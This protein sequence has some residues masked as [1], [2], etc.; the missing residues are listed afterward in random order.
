MRRAVGAALGQL[1]RD[2]QRMRLGA[3]P[4]ASRDDAFRVLGLLGTVS[5]TIPGLA[6]S[7]LRQPSVYVHLRLAADGAHDPVERLR[8]GLT[9]LALELAAGGALSEPLELAA[10]ARRV[11][12]RSR[13]TVLT[14]ATGPVT[15]T[16]DGLAVQEGRR[17][18]ERRAFVPIRGPLALALEDDSPLAAVEAHPDKHGSRLDLGGA[19]PEAWRASLADA[20]RRLEAHL[21]AMADELPVVLSQVVPVGVDPERHLSA[22]YREG[23]GTIYLSLHPDPLTMTEAVLHEV[24]H[25]KLHAVL[26]VQ[27]LLD[28]DPLER[29]A[30]PVRPDLRPLLGVLLAVHAFVPVAALYAAMRR[31]DD[32][33]ARGPRAEGRIAQVVRGN[34]EGLALLRRHA[35]PTKAGA[36]LLEELAALHDDTARALA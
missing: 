13:G 32:P 5:K 26:A 23:L 9:T 35:R 2:L 3:L 14:L 17:C 4:H 10:P 20:L 12:L 1:V 18:P 22:S 33:L 15:L 28:N 27:P 24:Q 8:A 29:Y 30:S 31:A 21:P 34:T 25:N 6:W 11:L 19:S 16:P 7:A 36:A